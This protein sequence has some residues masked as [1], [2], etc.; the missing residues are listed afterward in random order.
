MIYKVRDLGDA[1]VVTR[2]R[3]NTTWADTDPRGRLC[4]AQAKGQVGK[5]DWGNMYSGHD[6][7]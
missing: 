2:T 4:G 1:D 3:A 7:W 5:V 6:D